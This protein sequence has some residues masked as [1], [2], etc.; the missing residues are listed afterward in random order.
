MF[1]LADFLQCLVVELKSCPPN[2]V[3]PLRKAVDEGLVKF[4]QTIDPDAGF[5]EDA[6]KNGSPS[7]HFDAML[8][9]IAKLKSKN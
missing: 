3:A 6:R 4:L 1:D 5:P 8:D 9:A 2:R 7:Y